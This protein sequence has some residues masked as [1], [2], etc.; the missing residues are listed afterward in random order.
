M[1]LQVIRKVTNY[2]RAV[3]HQRLVRSCDTKL[4]KVLDEISQAD[5]A[6]LR[7]VDYVEEL[8]RRVGLARDTRDIYGDD[9][10]FMNPI[11]RG[12]WQIPKQLAECVVFLSHHQVQSFVEIGTFTGY[13]F[14]FMVGYLD[15]FNPG[16]KG[17]TLDINDCN[18]VRGLTAERYN[19]AFVIGTSKDV[20]GQSFD[21]CL[22][23]GDHSFSAVA[24]D[25]SEVGCKAKMCLFHDI[26]DLN[27]ESASAN[28]G[29]VPR[30]WRDLR[31]RQRGM[32]FHEFIKHTRGSRIMGIGL[33]MLSDKKS[34]GTPSSARREDAT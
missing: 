29:G 1:L 5:L 19:T 9:E 18:P 13:T 34:P 2:L 22:I 30:F 8:V 15:R 17:L 24:E 20:A 26:N 10:R 16:L 14:A 28:E 25:F 32:E 12:L 27:V 21:L 6:R 33:V 23:D 31:D 3:N 11:S 4:Q 7:Q